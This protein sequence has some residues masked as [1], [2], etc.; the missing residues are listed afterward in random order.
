MSNPSWPK[1]LRNLASKIR[2]KA[3]KAFLA[4]EE[5]LSLN[6]TCEHQVTSSHKYP[7]EDLIIENSWFLMILDDSW[8]CTLHQTC[9]QFIKV[10]HL[11]AKSVLCLQNVFSF[12][13]K[14]TGRQK[15]IW[16]IQRKCS[17]GYD[18]WHKNWCYNYCYVASVYGRIRSTVYI[19][20]SFPLATLLLQVSRTPR[21]AKK[22]VE[23]PRL[24]RLS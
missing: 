3:L 24:H 16:K 2:P 5:D 14:H 6:T 21:A 9:C 23:T 17:N 12:N 19:H 20:A 22:A 10:E 1:R 15:W 7:C 11:G 18:S 8:N 4:K 13:W